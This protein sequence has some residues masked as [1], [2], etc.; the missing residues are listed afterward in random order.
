MDARGELRRVGAVT[1]DQSTNAVW[2]NTCSC[3]DLATAIVDFDADS[4][5]LALD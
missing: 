3:L 2:S 4:D 5:E 1:H